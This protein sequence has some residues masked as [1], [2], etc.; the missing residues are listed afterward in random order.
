MEYD[1]TGDYP[2]LEESVFNVVS[3][4][5]GSLRAKDPKINKDAYIT[6]T[7]VKFRFTYTYNRKDFTGFAF[8]YEEGNHCEI[9]AFYPLKK[10]YSEAFLKKLE[11]SITIE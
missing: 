5:S 11:D 4:M 10:Q 9:V 7:I 2:P 3:S 1:F 6:D 8:G